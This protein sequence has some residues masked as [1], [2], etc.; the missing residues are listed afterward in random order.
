ME[1]FRLRDAGWM[2]KPAKYLIPV[3][4]FKHWH[5]QAAT[6]HYNLRLAMYAIYY[7]QKIIRTIERALIGGST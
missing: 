2:F 1:R 6:R 3:G 4:I 5:V 7:N